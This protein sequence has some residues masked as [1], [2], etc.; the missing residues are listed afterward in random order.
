MSTSSLTNAATNSND[1]SNCTRQKAKGYFL[2]KEIMLAALRDQARYKLRT[3]IYS[4][5]YYSTQ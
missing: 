5:K 2:D 1:V 4:L 3:M